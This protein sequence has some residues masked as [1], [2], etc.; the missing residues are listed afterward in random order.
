[1]QHQREIYYGRKAMNGEQVGVTPDEIERAKAYPF[2]ELHPFVRNRSRCPI[3]D[4][5]N[6]TSF[7][8]LKDNTA[9]CHVCQ[10]HGD[11][12]KYVR[13]KDGKSFSEAVRWLAL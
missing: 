4:G 9:R 2:G 7:E 8:L 11:T 13:D 12:I 10:W 6:P 1:V 3:H 5:K